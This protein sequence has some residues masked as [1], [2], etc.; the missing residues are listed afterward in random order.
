M[1]DLVGMFLSIIA[2]KMVFSRHVAVLLNLSSCLCMVSQAHSICIQWNCDITGPAT[3]A[4]LSLFKSTLLPGPHSS[5]T[6]EKAF[7]H[8]LSNKFYICAPYPLSVQGSV[9]IGCPHLFVHELQ[10]SLKKNLPTKYIYECISQKLICE[11]RSYIYGNYQVL[12]LK[13]ALFHRQFF[14]SLSF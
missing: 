14:C 6:P 9:Q 3:T 5:M 4:D 10:M 13:L 8:I 11:Q 1:N 2:G 7:F 12:P